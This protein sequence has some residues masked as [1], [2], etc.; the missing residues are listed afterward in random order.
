VTT[1]DGL[2]PV[3]VILG[4]I[5][6]AATLIY[7]ICFAFHVRILGKVGAW[8][9]W[10]LLTFYAVGAA[11]S[12]LCAI[13]EW[14]GAFEEYRYGFYGDYDTA[15]RAWSFVLVSVLFIFLFASTRHAVAVVQSAKAKS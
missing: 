2:L 8:W 1:I 11:I 13:L 14:N 3:A 12:F 9:A 7:T 6:V 4:G 5:I 15:R 10:P